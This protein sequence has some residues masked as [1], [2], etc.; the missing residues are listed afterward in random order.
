M[1]AKSP[2]LLSI[3]LPEFPNRAR[4]CDLTDQLFA[5]GTLDLFVTEWAG[6]AI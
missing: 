5:L 3:K 1:V 6:H 4:T 2:E